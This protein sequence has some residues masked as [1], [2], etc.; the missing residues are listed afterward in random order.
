MYFVEF[1]CIL[2]NITLKKIQKEQWKL[3]EKEKLRIENILKRSIDVEKGSEKPSVTEEH[4]DGC[5]YFINHN[6]LYH[7]YH[8]NLLFNI[9]NKFFV[10]I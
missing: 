7:N 6:Y 8:N 4:P 9:F 10:I 5:K 2:T 3:P 1:D